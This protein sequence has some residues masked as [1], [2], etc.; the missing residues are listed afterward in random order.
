VQVID[1][2]GAGDA[3]AAG[4]IHGWLGG[5]F[6]LGLRY[7][8][9]LAALVLGQHGDMLVTTEDELLSLLKDMSGGVIR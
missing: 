8:V 7:G 9:I 6:A 4:I 2:I 5:D 3:L 1:R